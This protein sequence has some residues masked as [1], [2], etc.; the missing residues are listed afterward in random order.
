MECSDRRKWRRRSNNRGLP[1][2]GRTHQ[3]QTQQCIGI[4]ARIF[5][6]S[7][8]HPALVENESIESYFVVP[9]FLS[10]GRESIALASE[11]LFRAIKFSFNNIKDNFPSQLLVIPLSLLTFFIFYFSFAH[12]ITERTAPES[13]HGSKR[14]RETRISS[15]TNSELSSKSPFQRIPATTPF[16]FAPV[17]PLKSRA[18][19]FKRSKH[20]SQDLAFN[21]SSGMISNASW[22]GWMNFWSTD[23]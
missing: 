4:F 22:F 6:T 14:Y 23:S 1:L 19:A 2:P 15:S 10:I 13:R 16:G 3:E 18:T 9:V 5:R 11:E 8:S 12:P 20:G 7:V 21:Q 17:G